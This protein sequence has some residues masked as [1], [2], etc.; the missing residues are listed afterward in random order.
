[1]YIVKSTFLAVDGCS[2]CIINHLEA[3]NIINY[4][5]IYQLL[6]E[7]RLHVIVF[8]TGLLKS[9]SKFLIHLTSKRVYKLVQ[10]SI[11]S[12]YTTSLAIYIQ[13]FLIVSRRIKN[14]FTQKPRDGL[15]QLS[16]IYNIIFL[17]PSALKRTSRCWAPNARFYLC[18]CDR[19][20]LFDKA[21]YITAGY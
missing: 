16:Y 19:C 1:M 15:V 4:Y 12:Y 18:V 14:Y 20:W 6:L 9:S 2:V 8:G 3:V 17:F 10:R 13:V 21:K 11:I 7:K 5:V